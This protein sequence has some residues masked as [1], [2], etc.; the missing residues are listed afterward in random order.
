MPILSESNQDELR[1]VLDKEM[2]GDVKLTFFTKD[3]SPRIVPGRECITCKQTGELLHEVTALSEKLQLDVH[4][5]YSEQ[6]LASELG[7]HRIPAFVLEGKA[8][9]KVRF[10]GIPAGLEFP[11]FIGDLLDVSK[12]S[13]TLSEGS[14]EALGTLKKD[15]HIQVFTTPT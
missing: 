1:E 10:F 11:A 7:I 14:R 5:F 6:E 12:G 2:V 3:D 13:T 15:V 8:K 4:D 9:G